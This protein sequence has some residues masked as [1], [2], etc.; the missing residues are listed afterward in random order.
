MDSLV[1]RCIYVHNVLHCFSHKQPV[2]Q[3]SKTLNNTSNPVWKTTF[4]FEVNDGVTVS[5]LL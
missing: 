3:Q 5:K 2:V 4:E 1:I